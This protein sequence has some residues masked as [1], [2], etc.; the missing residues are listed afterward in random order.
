MQERQKTLPRP[1]G[2]G[3][4]TDLCVKIKSISVRVHILAVC[5]KNDKLGQFDRTFEDRNTGRNY[6]QDN[7]KQLGKI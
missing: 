4:V 7:E 5:N 6:M 1:R 3:A 2:T